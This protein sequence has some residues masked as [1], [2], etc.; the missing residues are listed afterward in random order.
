MLYQLSYTPTRPVPDPELASVGRGRG[1]KIT[2]S[3]DVG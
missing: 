3:N 1:F 2:N